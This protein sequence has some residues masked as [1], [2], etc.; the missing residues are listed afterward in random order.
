MHFHDPCSAI[1]TSV[2]KSYNWLWFY[3]YLFIPIQLLEENIAGFVKTELKR[4]Q[5]ILSQDDSEYLETG[6]EVEEM[7]DIKKKKQLRSSRTAF[8]EITLHF[9]RRMN[10]EELAESLQ[11]SKTTPRNSCWEK[12]SKGYT[13]DTIQ[14]SI[15]TSTYFLLK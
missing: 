9:L 15:L 1:Q 4:I 6:S 10:Q 2:H 5:R 12:I 8:L 13:N 11:S 14:T 7:G 3:S